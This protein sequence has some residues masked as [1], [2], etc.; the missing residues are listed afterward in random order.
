VEALFKKGAKISA[1]GTY[2]PNSQFL[3][4]NRLGRRHKSHPRNSN[5]RPANA[6]ARLRQEDAAADAW[7]LDSSGSDATAE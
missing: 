4:R 3:R 5:P 1:K 2:Q 6:A 7:D